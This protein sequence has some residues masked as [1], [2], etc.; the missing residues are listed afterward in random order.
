[1]EQIIKLSWTACQAF[2]NFNYRVYRSINK[3]SWDLLAE[4]ITLTEYFDTTADYDI[5]YY[6]QIRVYD[7]DTGR[8]FFWASGVSD[9]L[10]SIY[11]D[12]KALVEIYCC[13]KFDKEVGAEKKITLYNSTF[14]IHLPKRLYKVDKIEINK[15]KLQENDYFISNNCWTIILKNRADKGWQNVLIRG[16]WGWP[17]LPS[18]VDQAIWI[19][20]KQTLLRQD[21]EGKTIE[22]G[23]FKSE[24]IGDYSYTLKDKREL[25]DWPIEVKLLLRN[26]RK[27]LGVYIV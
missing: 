12:K 17:S 9:N 20:T 16:D 22:W 3:V 10:V 11:D 19:L 21:D 25:E 26:Y 8:E 24:K 2:T 5:L 27:P 14:Q 1:M 13:Q 7:I 4:N 23:L 6:Y 18:D 15:N